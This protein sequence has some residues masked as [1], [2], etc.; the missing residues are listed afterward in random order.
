MQFPKVLLSAAGCLAVLTFFPIAIH[1]QSNQAPAP[2]SLKTI[3]I[4]QPPNI[5]DFVRNKD[6][7]IALGKALFWD[8]QIGSDGV[9]ACASCHFSAGAD[10]RSKNQ[11]NPGLRRVKGDTYLPDPD[12]AISKGAN[13]QLS[14][15]DFPFHRLADPNNHSS[16]VLADNNDVVSSQGVLNTPFMSSTAGSPSDQT[17]PAPDPDGF[18]VGG[19]NVRRVEP[20]N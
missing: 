1:S 11:L 9:V 17:A 13:A 14:A 7:A 3:P 16:A 2:P 19:V 8:M 5:A 6:M 15:A 18:Q 12:R 10:S 20:R 4:P